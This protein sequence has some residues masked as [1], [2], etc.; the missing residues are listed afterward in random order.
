[1][2]NPHKLAETKLFG[3][4]GGNLLNRFCPQKK[5]NLEPQPYFVCWQEAKGM[6]FWAKLVT[7]DSDKETE[8]IHKS[9]D[10]P[11]NDMYSLEKKNLNDL[12]KCMVETNRLD[13]WKQRL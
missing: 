4:T 10:I 5:Y 8:I 7:T 12:S 13:F 11:Q 6:N 1:M 3:D 9:A 2:L